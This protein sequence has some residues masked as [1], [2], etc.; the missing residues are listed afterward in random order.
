MILP[1]IITAAVGIPV[2]L[3]V[4]YIG[5]VPFF[6]FSL[7]I[8]IMSL[9]EYNIMMKISMKAV[10]TLSLFLCGVLFPF[11]FYFNGAENNSLDFF[12][13]LVS[14]AVILPFINEILRKE[15]YF[16]RPAYTIVGIFLISFNLSYLILIR[17]LKPYGSKILFITV[18]C[19]WL[20]DTAAY[21]IG[22]KF[23]K[24]KLNSVSPKKTIEGFIASIIFSVAF[25]FLM[26]KVS[27]IFGIKQFVLFGLLIS[28]SGQ[29][30]D[31]AESLIKRACGVKDSSNLLPGH[32]GFMDRFDSYF[33]VAP[34]VY[35]FVIFLR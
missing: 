27:P 18:F 23:G 31:L 13:L 5:G 24:N 19:V 30:S 35:Y 2:V 14:F 33:F 29:L 26:A 28:L 9:Y 17:D 21:F 10:D 22:S 4:M 1:R 25:M 15:K 12:P 6:I 34:F 20:T 8:I 32:G 7:F 3:T 16:E 11:A